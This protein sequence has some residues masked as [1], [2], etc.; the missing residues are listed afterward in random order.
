MPGPIVCRN[1]GWKGFL[2]QAQTEGGSLLFSRAFS[3]KFAMLF[4]FVFSFSAPGQ[5]RKTGGKLWKVCFLEETFFLPLDKRG[6]RRRSCLF[7]RDRWQRKEGGREHIIWFLFA[8]SLYSFGCGTFSSILYKGE[9]VRTNFPTFLWQWCYKK[10]NGTSKN[11]EEKCTWTECQMDVGGFSQQRQQ[12]LQHIWKS[13]LIFPPGHFSTLSACFTDRDRKERKTIIAL[14]RVRP[15]LIIC[16]CC[17]ASYLQ[18]EMVG[19]ADIITVW[20]GVQ[21]FAP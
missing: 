13:R 19:N 2:H 7:R 3:K 17:G 9:S 12:Q 15:I 11:K 8:F 6:R 20:F 4:F 5:I 21:R 14:R 10:N 18:I 1:S 16:C